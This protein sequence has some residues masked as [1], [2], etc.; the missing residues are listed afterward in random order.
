[1]TRQL[2]IAPGKSVA[3]APGGLHVML[4]GF[5]KQHH[6]RP[7]RAARS[8]LANGTHGRGSGGGAPAG[9]A[10]SVTA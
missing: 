1:M 10:V 7:D 3:F 6:H 8:V 4:S 9:R 2:V 5:K